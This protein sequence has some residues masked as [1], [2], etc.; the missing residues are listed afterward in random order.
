MCHVH[1]RF[2]QMW[3]PI[4]GLAKWRPRTPSINHIRGRLTCLTSLCEN[5]PVILQTSR[6]F[7][8]SQRKALQE[9]KPCNSDAT[10]A[11]ASVCHKKKMYATTQTTCEMERISYFVTWFS[12]FVEIHPCPASGCLET[13]PG[14][15]LILFLA[16][17]IWKKITFSGCRFPQTRYFH[18]WEAL[19]FFIYTGP[20][21]NT[22]EYKKNF[23][24]GRR[25]KKPNKHPSFSQWLSQ[26]KMT[27]IGERTG[28]G[29]DGASFL[30]KNQKHFS[31]VGRSSL[32]L[33]K[34]IRCFC[35]SGWWRTEKKKT[36]SAGSE[37][38][39]KGH[40][41]P[42][43]RSLP[44]TL[45]FRSHFLARLAFQWTPECVYPSL[46]VLSVFSRIH[47]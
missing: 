42:W 22:P 34:K 37:K 7:Q 8:K 41:P 47:G 26:W 10:A 20:G 9:L 1:V 29:R 46:K 24:I 35:P 19:R 27:G 12:T 40:S 5:I 23:E 6:P 2:G 30:V 4:C 18:A 14:S 45:K 17:C 31:E 39:A 16:C 13:Q 36:T 21:R 25:K 11:F 33:R 3:S 44:K 38:A 43:K 32:W 28:A 15:R